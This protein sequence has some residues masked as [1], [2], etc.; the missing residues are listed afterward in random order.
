MSTNLPY[1]DLVRVR[2]SDT[3]AQGHLYFANYLVYADE[4]VG[5]Y[6]E[7]LGFSAMNPGEAPCFIFTVNLNCSYLDECKAFDT[8]R[9]CVGYSRLGNSSAD[10]SFELYNDA[11]GTLLAR[12]SFTQVFT[13]KQTRKSTPIPE[14]FRQAIIVRQQGAGDR[15]GAA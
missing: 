4:V 3:D 12:G 8:V 2:F 15:G 13:D 1:S 6:M 9:V 5:H 11:S 10:V 7:E 14:A